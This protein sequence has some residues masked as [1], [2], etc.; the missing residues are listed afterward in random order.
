LTGGIGAGASSTDVYGL[1]LPGPVTGVHRTGTPSEACTG[2]SYAIQLIS[3]SVASSSTD[4]DL[5]FIE[6]DT[7]ATNTINQKL[8]LEGANLSTTF[9]T[10]KEFGTSIMRN[11]DEAMTNYLYLALTNNDGGNATGDIELTLVY[12]CLADRPFQ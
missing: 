5:K 10:D 4:L 8:V 7:T 3:V 11:R 1:E 6:M 12:M 2:E 9:N